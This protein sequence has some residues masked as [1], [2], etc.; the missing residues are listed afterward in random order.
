MRAVSKILLSALTILLLTQCRMSECNVVM[1]DVD[2]DNW[3]DETELSY[4][5]QQTVQNYDLSLMLHVNR[6]FRAEQ[7]EVE[8]T[9]LTPDSLRYSERVVL[10]VEFSWEDTTTPTTDIALP[11]RTDVNLRCEGEYKMVITPQHSVVGVEAA[12]INF[13]MKR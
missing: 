8:V 2:I 5:N 3:S 12:G 1:A 10:P 9:M 7:L 13:Q 6:R 11:Y 4:V